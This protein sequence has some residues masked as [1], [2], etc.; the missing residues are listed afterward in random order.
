VAEASTED[1][2]TSIGNTKRKR[3]IP[4]MAR[5]E[6]GKGRPGKTMSLTGGNTGIRAFTTT[7]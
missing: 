1:G 5:Q 6:K 4:K 2:P 3:H 7:Y